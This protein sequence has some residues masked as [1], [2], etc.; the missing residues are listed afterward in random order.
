MKL[1]KPILLA[2][3]AISLLILPASAVIINASIVVP[4]NYESNVFT[5]LQYGNSYTFSTGS[6]VAVIEQLIMNSYQSDVPVNFVFTTA[7]GNTI[8]GTVKSH[9]YSL[10]ESRVIAS[11]NGG[12]TSSSGSNF[13]NIFN[14]QPPG[15]IFYVYSNDTNSFYMVFAENSRFNYAPQSLTAIKPAPFNLD[16]DKDAY[17]TLPGNPSDDPVIQATWSS[18]TI[19][20]YASTTY[21]PLQ[22]LQRDEVVTS[23]VENKV[24]GNQGTLLDTILGLLTAIGGF[25]QSAGV[26]VTWAYWYG[27]VF[28]AAATFVTLNVMYLIISMVLAVHGTSNWVTA[29]RKFIRSVRALVRFY[30]EIFMYIKETLK[31]W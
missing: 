29:T 31:W 18:T 3:V 13:F 4:T 21:C 19:S 15:S 9:S 5:D 1:L 28:F 7:G 30:H 22:K 6:D 8:S 24:N 12:T 25:I 10:F 2:F 23:N 17:L 26:Y 11:F 16:L 20:F 27:T 14:L